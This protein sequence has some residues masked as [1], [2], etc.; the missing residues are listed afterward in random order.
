MDIE[1]GGDSVP[2]NIGIAKIAMDTEAK[3]YKNGIAKV[4]YPEMSEE[5]HVLL[6]KSATIV[7]DYTQQVLQDL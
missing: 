2:L 6:K 5:E 1:L 4:I 7:K 3:K